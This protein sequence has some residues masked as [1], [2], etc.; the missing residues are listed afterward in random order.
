[1][2]FAFE[3]IIDAKVTECDKMSNQKLREIISPIVARGASRDE[4][5]DLAAM[6]LANM[7]LR[8]AL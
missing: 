1:M 4:L 5:I 6:K 3:N 2:N 7:E 8:D